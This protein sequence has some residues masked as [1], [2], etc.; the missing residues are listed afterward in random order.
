MQKIK[1]TKIKST[2]NFYIFF[3]KLVTKPEI[4]WTFVS[5][6]S[7]DDNSILANSENL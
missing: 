1:E 6:I 7:I 5:P 4:L 3:L 2:L